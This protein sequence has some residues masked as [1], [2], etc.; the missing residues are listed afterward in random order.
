MKEVSFVY[1][2]Y[3]EMLMIMVNRSYCKILTLKDKIHPSMWLPS[4]AQF[5]VIFIHVI[6]TGEMLRTPLLD[7]LLMVPTFL[8]FQ[9][10][11]KIRF[12][13]AIISF[14]VCGIAELV[15]AVGVIAINS[16]HPQWK[17]IPNTW[18]PDNRYI[19]LFIYACCVLF[20]LHFLLR[21]LQQRL[22]KKLFQLKMPWI[23]KL[24]LSMALII[25]F[26]NFAGGM[27]TRAKLLEYLPLCL[28][29]S[30]FCLWL[31]ISSLSELEKQEKKNKQLKLQR[32]RL[33]QRKIYFQ[34]VE[35]QYQEIRKWN[36]DIANHLLA[37]SWLME[38]DEPEKA[39]QYIDSLLVEKWGGSEK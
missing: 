22:G 7:L 19:E 12:F 5:I 27:E 37:L 38:Q 6:C 4:L 29:V 24:S 33:E 9:D 18:Y 21:Q 23:L 11:L 26:A 36:H 32:V 31:Q 8:C 34:K 28:L 10:K 20:F 13:A 16:I 14:L 25:I 30:G 35:K 2:F 1:L 39:V 15:I 3:T 17:M